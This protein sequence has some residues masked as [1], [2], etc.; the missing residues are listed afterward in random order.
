MHWT[1]RRGTSS[2]SDALPVTTSGGRPWLKPLAAVA[3]ASSI[4]T[5]TVFAPTAHAADQFGNEISYRYNHLSCVGPDNQFFWTYSSC[6]YPPGYSKLDSRSLNGRYR[7][8]FQADGNWVVYDGDTAIWS[9]GTAGRGATNITFQ[10]DNNIVIYRNSTPLW[11]SNPG[12]KCGNEQR[13]I[14]TMQDDGNLVFTSDTPG[15][16]T[17]P[18]HYTIMWSSRGGTTCR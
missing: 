13:K 1:G 5:A 8:T 17:S 4:L 10:G 15:D 7:S 2:R 6:S 11:S 9:S 3:V 12:P 16:F 18:H 14:L